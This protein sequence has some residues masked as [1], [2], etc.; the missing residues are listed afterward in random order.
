MQRKNAVNR[1]MASDL[2]FIKAKVTRLMRLLKIMKFLEFLKFSLSR[3]KLLKR[4]VGKND[5]RTFGFKI[6]EFSQ[7]RC[8]KETT[9]VSKSDK[10]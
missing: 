7:F 5:F 2:L 3:L 8:F 10:I 4:G 9:K 1:G 6:F